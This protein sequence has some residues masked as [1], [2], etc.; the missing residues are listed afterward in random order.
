[1]STA[2]FEQGPRLPVARAQ[3]GASMISAPIRVGEIYDGSSAKERSA[4]F[5]SSEAAGKSEATELSLS[6]RSAAA[7]GGGR[8]EGESSRLR[9]QRHRSLALTRDSRFDRP[10]PVPERPPW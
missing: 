5:F 1:M 2:T 10:G 7:G 9:S 3:V 6:P 4:P 8:S